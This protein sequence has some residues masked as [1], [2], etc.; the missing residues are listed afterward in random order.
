MQLGENFKSQGAKW[1][2]RSE[3]PS[4]IFLGKDSCPTRPIRHRHRAP[5]HCCCATLNGVHSFQE[6]GQ[7]GGSIWLR[8]FIL[9]PAPPPPNAQ[10]HRSAMPAP[11]RSSSLLRLH[12]ETSARVSEA[13]HGCAPHAVLRDPCG[14]QGVTSSCSRLSSAAVPSARCLLHSCEITAAAAASSTSASILLLR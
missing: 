10:R 2:R 5:P 3:L 14:R 1:E 6:Q 13:V 11:R 7:H 9:L 4:G 12:A 8:T